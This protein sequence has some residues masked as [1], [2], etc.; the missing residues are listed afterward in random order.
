MEKPVSIISKVPGGQE[1]P[2]LPRPID[3]QEID[4]LLLILPDEV[5]RNRLRLLWNTYVSVQAALV[6]EATAQRL[7]DLEKAEAALLKFMT[8]G[9]RKPEAGKPKR[10][11]TINLTSPRDV[12]RLLSSTINQLRHGTADVQRARAIVY[13]CSVLLGCFDSQLMDERVSKM[14]SILEERNK[15]EV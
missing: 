3:R 11:Y 12:R 9:R 14:E 13:G 4:E 8:E 15:Q 6:K 1:N 5:S 10:P 7:R 2:D